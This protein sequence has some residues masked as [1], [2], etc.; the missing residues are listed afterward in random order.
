MVM[1]DRQDHDESHS[2]DDMELVGGELCLDFVNTASE[3]ASGAP[4]RDRLTGY[5]DLVGWGERT[6]ALD[7][8]TAEGLRRVAAARPEEAEAVLRRAKSLREAIFRVFA[9]SSGGAAPVAADL[10]ELSAA[11]AEASA[12][13]RL[14]PTAHGFDMAWPET[15]ALDRAWWP[16][17]TS[18]VALLVSED[19][20]RVKECATDNCS[21]LF[22]DLSRNRSRRWCSMKDCG[23]R[24]KARRHYARTR[25]RP[26]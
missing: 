19:L 17:A 5:A 12:A 15:E 18:A 10:A 21:W 11:A 9:T 6:G 23:N 24:A 20:S 22:L 8:A 7:T 26:T 14:T 3:R 1:D 2:V 13:Q 16:A 4:E 25:T